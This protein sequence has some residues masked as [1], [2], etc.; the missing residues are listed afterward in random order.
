MKNQGLVFALALSVLLN[1]GV[2]GAAG[3]RTIA[4]PP[5][6]AAGLANRLE[7][8]PSQRERWHALEQGFVRELDAGWGEIAAHREA[9]VRE[10]FADQPDP[11]RI[12][13]ERARIA[14]LQAQQQQRVIA[15][16][17]RERDILSAEQRRA[18]VD[19]LLREGQPTPVE[20]Q[21]HGG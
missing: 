11:A 17:L 15:Q 18:L 5:S 9:L 3:Y 13:A 12:E 8:D 1:L 19:L 21:L 10:V 6:D 4:R 20:R 16:F 14:Q 7:L 2:V